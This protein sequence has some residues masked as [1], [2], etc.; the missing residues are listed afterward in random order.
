MWKFGALVAFLAL[1]T[2][3]PTAEAVLLHLAK[4]FENIV[5][6]WSDELAQ[7]SPPTT[8]SKVRAS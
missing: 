2:L 6:S 3:L 1:Q 5:A 8:I 4:K 7:H